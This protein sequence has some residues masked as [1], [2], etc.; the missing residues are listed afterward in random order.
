MKLSAFWKSKWFM[1][2]V[3]AAVIGA[4]VVWFVNGRR[5][6]PQQPQNIVLIS[7]D[8]TRSD[9]LSCYGYPRQTTPNID[10]LASEGFLF[11]NTISPQPFTLPA[12]CSMLT[13]TVPPYHGVL[14]N[15]DYKL[16]DENDVLSEILKTRGFT[17]AGFVSSFVLDS[18]F[19]LNQGFD[20]YDDPFDTAQVSHEGAERRGDETTDRAIQWLDEKRGRKNFVFLHYFDP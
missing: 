4:V 8:T 16:G 19:G 14:D 12:H 9:F 11:S 5:R 3:M 18:Q 2:V 1:T 20:V 10:A 17:T 6:G 15:R 7:M 13:G